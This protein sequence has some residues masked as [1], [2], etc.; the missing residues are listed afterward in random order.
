MKNRKIFKFSIF[1]IISISFTAINSY[2]VENI[3]YSKNKISLEK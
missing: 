2:S 1:L 3:D